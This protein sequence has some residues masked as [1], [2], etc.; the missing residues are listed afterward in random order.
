MSDTDTL[1]RIWLVLRVSENSKETGVLNQ[2]FRNEEEARWFVKGLIDI[3]DRSNTF[4][5]LT[6]ELK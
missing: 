3:N 1:E 4:S 5:L 6:V 2:A